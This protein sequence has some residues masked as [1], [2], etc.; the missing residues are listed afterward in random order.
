VLSIFFSCSSG[1]NGGSLGSGTYCYKFEQSVASALVSLEINSDGSVS[2]IQQNLITDKQGN[3]KSVNHSHFSGTISGDSLDL[4]L[5]KDLKGGLKT[6]SEIWMVNDSMLTTAKLNLNPI[7]C[8][9]D[10]WV[11]F[12]TSFNIQGKWQHEVNKNDFID[13]SQNICTQISEE[14]IGGEYVTNFN[15]R[16]TCGF[17]LNALGKFVVLQ[18]GVCIEINEMTANELTLTYP[19]QEPAKY[20]KVQ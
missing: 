13:F 19:G 4:V 7:D 17:R 6:S 9:K 18:S 8:P 14:R 2:G 3:K 11:D 12:P 1:S 16:D 20:S 5:T 10:K 15:I